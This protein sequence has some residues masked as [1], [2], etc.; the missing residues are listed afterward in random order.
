M[1]NLLYDADALATAERLVICVPGALSSRD[2]F[3]PVEDWA[4]EG[5]GVVCYRFPGLDGRPLKPPLNIQEAADEIV[6]FTARYPGKPI[7]LIGYSTGGPIV[8]SAATRLTGD[9]KIAAMSSAV[10]SGGG[11]RTGLPGLW[12]VISSAGRAMSMDLKAI[13][14]EYYRVLLFGRA[15]LHDKTLAHRADALIAR[16]RDRI[17]MPDGGKPRAHT[18]NLRLWR[19]PA[20]ARY[21]GR[22][23]RFFTGLADPVFS[24]RQTVDFAAR[25]GSDVQ[26]I[27]YP[28]QGHLLFLSCETIFDDIRAFFE[29]S[30]RPDTS[31]GEVI[32]GVSG[33]AGNST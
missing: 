8:L 16:H 23:L 30:A 10:E 29:D 28:R 15:V 17:V 18:D 4:A 22:Q 2:I 25:C 33:G 9:V 3:E 24:R 19:L 31:E 26:V 11:L 13:W 21:A 27:G 6:D 7:R 5:Y 1:G 14:M 20:T 12:D 32:A